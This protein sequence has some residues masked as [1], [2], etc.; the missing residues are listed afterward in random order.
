MLRRITAATVKVRRLGYFTILCRHLQ[1]NSQPDTQLQLSLYRWAKENR[2]DLEEYSASIPVSRRGRSLVVGEITIS[3]NKKSSDAASR[4]IETANHLGLIARIGAAT[5]IR[6]EWYN[7][8]LGHVLAALPGSANIF[9]LS[10]AQKFF[11]LGMLM[12]HDFLYLKV[13]LSLIDRGIQG[14]PDIFCKEVSSQLESLAKHSKDP[15][16]IQEIRKTQKELLT[17]E[18]P[19]SYYREQ[20]LAPRLEW[21]VDL[22]MIVKWR[23]TRVKNGVDYISLRP[24]S[25]QFFSTTDFDEK[26]IKKYYADRFYA[27]FKE[28]LPNSTRWNEISSKKRRQLLNEYLE[29]AMSTF[30]ISRTVDKMSASQFLTFASALILTEKVVIVSESQLELA[31]VEFTPGSA[32]RYVRMTSGLDVGYIVRSDSGDH[33]IH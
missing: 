28:E 12:K 21:L 8:K 27:C 2:N 3:K 30:A 17:W 14:K 9:R 13:I 23:Q 24:H 31:L 11:F 32:Y 29:R 15:R 18:S 20:I 25:R 6:G 19:E 10:I 33:I 4:Y 26:L 22:G 5:G 1:Q 16:V 7:T